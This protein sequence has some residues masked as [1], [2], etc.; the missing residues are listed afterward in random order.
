MKATLCGVFLNIQCQVLV[1]AN[2][3]GRLKEM[4]GKPSGVIRRK[5]K[6]EMFN[7]SHRKAAFFKKITPRLLGRLGV[8]EQVG[9]KISR[10]LPIQL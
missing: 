10:G 8:I 7:D 4:L 3:R 1:L 6:T 5:S 2:P 9:V